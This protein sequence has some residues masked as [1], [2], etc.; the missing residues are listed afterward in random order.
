MRAIAL[1][2]LGAV[3][4]NCRRL[5][6]GLGDGAELCAVV[7]ADG[8]GHGAIDCAAPRSPAARPGSRSRPRPRRSSC[9]RRFPEARMLVMG[10][11][12][13]RRARP[14]ARGRRRRRGLAAGLPASWSASGPARAASGRASTSSTTPAW[15]GSG[16]RDPD[17]VLALLA[18]TRPPPEVELVGPLDPLRDRGR[19]RLG[20]L[21]RAARA[22]PP[23]WSMPVRERTRT[24]SVHAANSAATLREPASHLDMVR[25]GVAI[26]GLDPFGADPARSGLEPALELH[27][28]VADVK[29]FERRR[30]RRVR[31]Q[32]AGAGRH[33]GRGAADRLRRRRPPGAL[34]QRRGADRRPPLPA[35]RHRLDG[36]RHGRPRPA[37]PT[38]EP[39][40]A[41]RS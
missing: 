31:A 10:A 25:C 21:R 5:A 33:L 36:Q 6:R 7:K 26:Y 8:Y 23:S 22:L 15:A 13:A 14:R 9:A 40:A 37:R 35:R 1:I 32:L 17:A 41:P 4:R 39:G 2:D 16:E 28:Y 19:A 20:V 3:E 34:Q 11:L 30:Q 27:S 29:R 18:A 12:D 24:S 38:V